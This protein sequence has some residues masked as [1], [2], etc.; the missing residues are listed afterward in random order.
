MATTT[1]KHSAQQRTMLSM[2][3]LFNS[4]LYTKY[5]LYPHEAA[6][7]ATSIDAIASF[8]EK[9]PTNWMRGEYFQQHDNH[10]QA[11]AL[12]VWENSRK[13]GVKVGN[14]N[15]SYTKFAS[16]YGAA[17]V[18]LN[19]FYAKDRRELVRNLRA[20]ARYLRL[21]ATNP[22]T[23]ESRHRLCDANKALLSKAFH[24]KFPDNPSTH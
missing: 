15:C 9:N 10:H 22:P 16:I 18:G 4:M 20:I 6:G 11:C 7:A 14:K 23:G 17:V 3:S 1:R 8:L 19:D 21:Y 24:A 2:Q 5:H 12:G 13:L